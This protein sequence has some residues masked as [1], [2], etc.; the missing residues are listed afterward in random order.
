MI[1]HRDSILIAWSSSL[2]SVKRAFSKLFTSNHSQKLS[3]FFRRTFERLIPINSIQESW[4]GHQTPKAL[5]WLA[6]LMRFSERL[7]LA[8]PWQDLQAWNHQQSLSSSA[9]RSTLHQQQMVF[10]QILSNSRQSSSLISPEISGAGWRKYHW[11]HNRWLRQLPLT[12]ERTHQNFTSRCFLMSTP[13]FGWALNM[14]FGI[15]YRDDMTKRVALITLTVI[16]LSP[17]SSQDLI[18]NKSTPQSN[19]WWW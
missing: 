11:L 18:G 13:D 2:P 8:S 6:S 3:S 9:Q 19:C 12:H 15:S 17:F 10:A 5:K 1:S 7:S 14:S 4:Y 16:L